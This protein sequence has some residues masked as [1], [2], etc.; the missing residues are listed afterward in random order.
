[1]PEEHKGIL[2]NAPSLG[3]LASFALRYA[4][5]R[6]TAAPSAAIA[7]VL[8]IFSQLTEWDRRQIRWEIQREMGRGGL[9]KVNLDDWQ[10]FLDATAEAPDRPL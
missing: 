7:Q 4:Y 1:M 6:E 8:P 5:G 3:V 9:G 10:R 2:V